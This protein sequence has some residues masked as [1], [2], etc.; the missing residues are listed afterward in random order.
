MTTTTIETTAPALSTPEQAVTFTARRRDLRLVKVPIYPVF[1]AGGMKVG[2]QPGET[3]QFTDGVF[4]CPTS[5]AVRLADGRDGDAAEVLAFLKAHRL[6]GNIFEGFVEVAQAEP[7]PSAD[8]MDAIVQAAEQLDVARIEELIATEEAGW[9]REAILTVARGSL[10]RVK[11][12][13]AEVAK[14]EAAAAQEPK[15]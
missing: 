4:T 6:N 10:E 5:G 13:Q 12:I 11:A 9:N 7:I 8:D 1:G 2:E 15:A 14:Q 3:I